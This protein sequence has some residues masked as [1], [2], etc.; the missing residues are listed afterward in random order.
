MLTPYRRVLGRPGGLAFSGAGFVARL[1]ISMVGLGCILLVSS[2]TGSYALAGSVSAALVLASG[3]AAIV[4]GRLIDRLGQ[5]RVL[6]PAVLVNSVSLSALIWA[7][8]AGYRSPLL[9]VLAALAGATM[10]AVGASVRARWSNL[11]D[12]DLE[13]QTAF[14]FE[15]VV[16]ESVFMIGPPLVT[17]LATVVHPSAGLVAAIVAGV[18]GTLAFAAQRR[19]EPPI[20]PHRHE[21]GVRVPMPWPLLLPVAVV[22]FGIGGLFGSTEVAT[23]AFADE[24]GHRGAAGPLLAAWAF[25]SLLAGVVSGSIAWRVG[26]ATRIRWGILALS[27]LMAP[28]PFVGSLGL[29]AVLLFLAGL[30]IAPTLIGTVSVVERTVP[31]SRLTEGM[32]IIHTTMAAGLAPGAALAGV[33]IDLGGASVAYLVPLGS[34]LLGAAAAFL[35]RERPARRVAA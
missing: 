3:A 14:A 19:T 9:H 13:I 35:T 15:A 33:V 20:R 10:P 22:S 32:T 5:A 8:S 17:L 7:V 18:V 12:S 2:R 29:M 21:D 28:M 6:V 24:L 11:L 25:G 4:H 23:V 30:A 26:P 31:A 16:D 27:I 34:G 1:P